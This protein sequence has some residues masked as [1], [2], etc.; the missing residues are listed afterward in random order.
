MASNLE[1]MSV[2][3]R[4]PFPGHMIKPR[5]KYLN[6]TSLSE[7]Q[8]KTYLI[9]HPKVFENFVLES[10]SES[11]LEELL[12]MKRDRPCITAIGEQSIALQSLYLKDRVKEIAEVLTTSYNEK[13]QQ[14]RMVETTHV[15]GR[16]INANDFAFY[17]PTHNETMLSLYHDGELVPCGPVGKNLTV[18][19]HAVSEKKTI[20]V[21]DLQMDPR[22]PK[23]ISPKGMKDCSVLC[24]PVVLPSADTV[25][26]ME[27]TRD[28]LKQPFSD[29]DVQVTNA[30]VS[31]M[32]ACI[33][34][35]GLKRIL[36][37]QH[38]LN[39]F[40]LEITK[41]LFKEITC[42]DKVAKTILHFTKD[43]LDADR[44][45]MYVIDEEQSKSYVAYEDTGTKD[46]D[47][48]EVYK[49][50][51]VHDLQSEDKI[52][53]EVIEKGKVINIY[54]AYDDERFEKETDKQSR[55]HT[56]H[57]LC[58][59][60][61]HKDQVFGVTK[62]INCLHHDHFTKADE[63]YFNLFSDYCALALHYSRIYSLLYQQQNIYKVAVDV[64]QY[65]IVCAEDEVL[66]LQRK[67][68]I[69][70]EAIPDNFNSID[71]Y[72]YHHVES[73]PRLFI[74][75]T[76]DLFGKD[77]FEMEKLCRFILTVRKNYRPVTYHNWEH[78]FHV[79]HALWQMIKAN[80]D[81]FTKFE[82]M[83]L[84][85]GGICHDLDHRG[86]NNDFFQKLNL[87]LASLYSTS[88]MEQHHYKQTITILHTEGQ[89]I[90]SFLNG[91]QYKEMLELLRN[92]IIAT[93]LALYFTNQKEASK[94][95]EEGTFDMSDPTARA[96]CEALM[97]TAADLCAVAKPW[98]TQI[99]TVD[100]LYNEF[101][102]QG[103]EEK[104]Q[105]LTPIPMMDRENSKD[106]PK[107][108]I[109][110]INFICMPLYNTLSKIINGV[111]PYVEGC[112]VNK[113]KWAEKCEQ[114]C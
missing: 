23:G 95:L 39:E 99:E 50:R 68:Y 55:Y 13:D 8:V 107:Q 25:G 77:T 76:S 88:V 19:A 41:G 14:R 65:H 78:G 101:Y 82:K 35:N 74:Y 89:D 97:M 85:I 104:K 93:D 44:C 51:K 6:G 111:E 3:K 36:D 73:L 96:C 87:P 62:I 108:Q 56:K 110:F 63:E 100:R 10:V 53:W 58:M 98:D 11:K 34:E 49:K 94:R 16:A 29:T 46:A 90:F 61:H 47:G 42:V 70:N 18:A 9:Q 43:L 38:E 17:V 103:D 72:A 66:S 92:H 26:V 113:E 48:E 5:W 20:V 54:N 112:L 69:E 32:A 79:A 109:G 80:E 7:L 30:V 33:H 37:T 60:I 102:Q 22:F 59:P 86:Y 40:L 75:I 84:I 2:L 91:P 15:L 71:F 67:P 1:Q 81:I 106:Q 52:A 4:V 45:S 12:Q 28:Q 57:I 27:F 105:G 114:G 83:A 24:V 21:R 64:L 31:W